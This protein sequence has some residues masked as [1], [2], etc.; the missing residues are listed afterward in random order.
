MAYMFQAYDEEDTWQPAEEPV[1]IKRIAPHTS[2]SKNLRTWG[3][4]G[5]VASAGLLATPVAAID[6]ITVPLSLVLLYLSA[7]PRQIQDQIHLEAQAKRDGCAFIFWL[8]LAGV[9]LL[10]V[11][12][13]AGGGA[14]MF[15]KATG[16]LQ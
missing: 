15:G 8:L 4:L 5:L 9:F 3:W 1:A 10:L 14:Y 7:L 12:G 6:L 13:S 11:L 2:E 16:R